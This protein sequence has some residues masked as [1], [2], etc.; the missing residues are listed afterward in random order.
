MG[1]FA[2]PNDHNLQQPFGA[3]IMPLLTKVKL[4]GFITHNSVHPP[5][6]SLSL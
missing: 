6:K 5:L 3:N 1:T 4:I 2:N